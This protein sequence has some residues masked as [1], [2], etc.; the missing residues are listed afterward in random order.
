MFL[1]E[2]GTL[3]AFSVSTVK[4]ASAKDVSHE[5]GNSTVDKTSFDDTA[6]NAAAVSKK[7]RRMS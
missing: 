4:V 6:L 5:M 7:S 1:T 2:P 3:V